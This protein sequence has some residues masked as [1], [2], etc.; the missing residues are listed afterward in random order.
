MK[1]IVLLLISIVIVF[2][3]YS[4]ENELLQ[5][6]IFHYQNNEFENAL[7]SFLQAK[8]HG[9]NNPDLLYNIGNTYFRL[10]NIPQAIIY[11]KRALLLDSSYKPAK[12]NLNYAMSLT[13][14]IQS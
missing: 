1:K 7:D 6:G 12:E 5:Q 11:Y 9:L 14:D 13:Q 3:L 8:E 4:T 10:D 2:S